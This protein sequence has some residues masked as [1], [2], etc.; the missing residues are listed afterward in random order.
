MYVLYSCILVR[1]GNKRL[2]L[3]KGIGPFEVPRAVCL[4]ALM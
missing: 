3:C 1:M 2:K 4:T